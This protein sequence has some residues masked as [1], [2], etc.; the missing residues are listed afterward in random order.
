MTKKAKEVK[1]KVQTSKE[2]Y[3]EFVKSLEGKTKEELEQIEKDLIEKMDLNDNDVSKV[4][5]DMPSENYTEAAEAIRYFLN[6][7]KVQWQYT[8]GLITLYEF[9]MAESATKIN[10]P[11]LDATLRNLGSMEFSGYDE[12]KKVVVVNDY[13]TPLRE[14]YVKYTE[15]TYLLAQEHSAVLDAMKIFNP[16]QEE[17]GLEAPVQ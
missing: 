10:Y 13:F 17:H 7:N 5:F 1:E 2:I 6:K 15:K 16:V 12:W 14:S 11:T 9:W 3:D 8:L 4:L